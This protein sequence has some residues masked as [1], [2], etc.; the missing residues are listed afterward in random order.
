MQ[1]PGPGGFE[2]TAAAAGGSLKSNIPRAQPRYLSPM[3]YAD[4]STSS[5]HSDGPIAS[6]RLLRGGSTK[7]TAMATRSLDRKFL[8]AS[9][10]AERTPVL[11]NKYALD[12][13]DQTTNNCANTSELF[14][15]DCSTPSRNRDAR[16][17]TVAN[18]FPKRSRSVEASA[19][20]DRQSLHLEIARTTRNSSQVI[21]RPRTNSN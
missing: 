6:P 8:A 10:D 21:R 7:A 3:A 13:P 20:N 4:P 11:F 16:A 2:S 14:A 15:D 5:R 19:N 9:N 18:T 17:A 12:E 1:S